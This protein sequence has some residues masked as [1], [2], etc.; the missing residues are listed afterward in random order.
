M[1]LGRLS[2]LNRRNET[3]HFYQ[4]VPCH[5]RAKSGEAGQSGEREAAYE[6]IGQPFAHVCARRDE[7]LRLEQKRQ[8]TKEGP[9]WGPVGETMAT[10]V[11]WHHGE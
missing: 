1:P 8:P 2:K 9:A 10:C 4:S 11:R 7:N 5:S 6:E 3:S